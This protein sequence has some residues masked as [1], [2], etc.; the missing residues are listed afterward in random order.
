MAPQ[1]AR[2]PAIRATDSHHVAARR[3]F[4]EAA[5][6]S[7]RT[8]HQIGAHEIGITDAIANWYDGDS[9]SRERADSHLQD[10]RRAGP[11][12]DPTGCLAPGEAH[13]TRA[14]ARWPRP[15]PDAPVA[16]CAGPIRLIPDDGRA[17]LV[18]ALYRRLPDR[19]RAGG[20]FAV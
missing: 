10:A 9:D 16:G 1:R 19:G 7:R 11:L 15:R 4:R 5:E 20:D 14:A 6:L 17:E 3:Q 8:P 12:R 2:P 13:A 18:R